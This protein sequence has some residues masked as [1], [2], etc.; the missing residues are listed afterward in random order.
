VVVAITY[1]NGSTEGSD[2]YVATTTTVTIPAGATQVLIPISTVE[3]TTNEPTE[4]FTINGT[5]TAGTTSNATATGT[6]TIN[7]DDALPALTIGDDTVTEGDAI[8][9]PVTLS[10]PSSEDVVVA[11]TYDNGS[12]E[13]ADDY[14]AT[15][16]TVTIP[17]GATQVLIPISTVEDTTN[18]PTESFTINGTVTAGTTSNATATGTGTINDDDDVPAITLGDV[19][20][21]EGTDPTAVI[22]VTLSN[23]SDEDVDVTVTLTSGTAG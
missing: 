19:T 4:S 15:T 22:P 3:D 5:V 21:T 16:T 2:D 13:G 17:A 9:I 20:V 8:S 18:E 14:V 23:P 6:G 7:D 1:D 11:I 10:N 12:T